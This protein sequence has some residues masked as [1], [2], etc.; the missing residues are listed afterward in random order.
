MATT[1][2]VTSSVSG[3]GLVPDEEHRGRWSRTGGQAFAV[4]DAPRRSGAT[5]D[6]LVGHEVEHVVGCAGSPVVARSRRAS[7]GGARRQELRHDLHLL[8]Q[9]GEASRASAMVRSA[10]SD[11]RR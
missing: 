8:E 5:G 2:E 11:R 6:E 4:G 10:A 7:G 9:D 1:S 3:T